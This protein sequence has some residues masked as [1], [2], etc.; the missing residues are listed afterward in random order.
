MGGRPVSRLSRH[1]HAARRRRATCLWRAACPGCSK[2]IA[3]CLRTRGSSRRSTQGHR[4]LHRVP[5]AVPATGCR[6][7][8]PAW[9]LAVTFVV[10]ATLNAALYAVFAS[11][12]R[13]FSRR[14][15][16]AR[17][18]TA[19]AAR[20]SPPRAVGALRASRRGTGSA[21]TRRCT[22]QR[23]F[24]ESIQSRRR[25]TRHPFGGTMAKLNIN[26][27]MRD[28]GGGA[29]HAAAVG[30][31][32]ERR[33]DRHQVRLRR[34]A[35]RRV[36]GAHQR[37]RRAL[38]RDA[39]QRGQADRPHRD[40]RGTVADERHAGAEGVAR[41]RRAAVRLLPV[42]ADHGG[43]GAACEEFAIRA[44]RRSTPR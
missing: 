36:L 18:S 8:S 16:P 15:R 28:V 2:A 20:C 24:V 12:A 7:R 31:P 17:A 4:L 27:K 40:H 39:G 9:V 21:T 13:K 5:A 30:D 43:D 44:T 42:G 41:A 6:R 22:S 14:R 11:R 32:R 26:G 34:R 35:M 38:V 10:L 25:A 1:S 3:A 29:R 23:A 19:P 33:A 37:Q